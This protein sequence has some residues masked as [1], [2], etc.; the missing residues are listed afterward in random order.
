MRTFSIGL[1][2]VCLLAAAGCSQQVE[3]DAVAGEKNA[4]GAAGVSAAQ[5]AWPATLKVMGDGYPTAGDPCRRLG[6][7]DATVNFLD[8]SATLVGCPGVDTSAAAKALLANTGAQVVGNLD[9][10]TMISIPSDPPIPPKADTPAGVNGATHKG[11]LTGQEIAEYTLEAREGQTINVSLEGRGSMY[12]N[13]AAP[14]GGAA[15]YVGSRAIDKADFWSGVAPETGDYKV[16]IYL[17]GNDR[18]AA[19][20]RAYELKVAAE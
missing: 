14:S 5:F 3:T 19:A 18:D 8:D 13:V 10:V 1:L 15:L 7:S 2:A 11:T 6:E 17:M 16:T 9:G 12:F 4:D 20:S